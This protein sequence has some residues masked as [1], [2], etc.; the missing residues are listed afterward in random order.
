MRYINGRKVP[1]NGKARS[2]V[3]EEEYG[4]RDFA[5]D[6]AR[7][8]AGTYVRKKREARIRDKRYFDFTL[9]R[10][11]TAKPFPVSLVGY[12]VVFSAIA[13]LLVRGN[14]LINEAGVRATELEGRLSREIERSVEL[15]TALNTRSDA[16]F[17]EDYAVN[18]LG[19]VK[20]TDV[21]KKYI[22]ITGEDK[23][24]TGTDRANS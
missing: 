20:S 14:T 24:V 6:A 19:M 17:V 3:R 5:G 10:T 15:D 7:A 1:Y 11:K 9:R 22:S 8:L 16:A 21:V 23:I 18:V 2:A 12:I 4:L 13:M